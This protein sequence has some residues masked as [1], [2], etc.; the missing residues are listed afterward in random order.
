MGCAVIDPE[1][2]AN[3]LKT[4]IE[5]TIDGDRLNV[6]ALPEADPELP[7]VIIYADNPFITYRR[8]FGARGLAEVRFRAEIRVAV[9]TDALGATSLIY[10]IA[11]T[12]TDMSLFDAI[13]AD[14]TLGA[15]VGDCVA[16]TITGITEAG[17]P[18]RPYLTAS[19]GIT[20]NEPRS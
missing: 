17:D 8:T 9:G 19:L 6:Y 3:A 14:H 5:A 20:I 1:A 2:F 12:G 4:T 15:V 16:E 13:G 7:A 18:A 11:G 10:A